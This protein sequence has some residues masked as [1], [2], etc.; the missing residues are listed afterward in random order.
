MNVWLDL[1]VAALIILFGYSGFKRGL[2]YMAINAVGTIVSLVAAS[3]VAS[4]LSQLVYNLLFRDNIINGLTEATAGIST[5][6]PV[7]AAEETLNAMS[8]FSLNVFSLLGINKDALGDT[9]RKSVIGI[10]GT[11]EEIIRPYALKT[12]S[13]VLTMILYLIM[14]V[15]VAFLAKKM[16][17]GIDRTVLGVPNKVLGMVLGVAE[18]VLIAMAVGLIVYFVMMFISPESCQSLRE[19]INNTVFYRAIE[20][21]SLP[22]KII[23]W[24]S[25]L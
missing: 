13:C 7:K 15:I 19:S 3:F 25:S 12:I 1:G 2:L 6:D 8:N 23:S 11:V 20:K 16:T 5:S 22:E 17:N 24:I 18:A 4:M 21:I 9:I 14:M 10:P